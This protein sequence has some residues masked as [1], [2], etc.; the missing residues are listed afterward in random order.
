FRVR[1]M[2]GA[3]PQAGVPVAIYDIHRTLVEQGITDAQGQYQSQQTGRRFLMAV[4]RTSHGE[5]YG[6]EYND[7][8]TDP[9]VDVNLLPTLVFRLYERLPISASAVDFSL[10]RF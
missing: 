10:K 7:T 8:K 3:Q 2:L 9:V 5:L 6:F 4:A 1:V